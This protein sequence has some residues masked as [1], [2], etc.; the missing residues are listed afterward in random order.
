MS[1][2]AKVE[3]YVDEEGRTIN[4]FTPID[5]GKKKVI[6]GEV[7]LTINPPNSNEPPQTMPFEFDFPDDYNLSKAQKSFDDV[8]QEKIDEW[9]KEVRKKQQ[10]ENESVI[11]PKQGI[12]M[13][14]GRI[15]DNKQ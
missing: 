13:P 7:G 14:D 4:V 8:A 9:E 5:R 15:I 1:N 10:Q 11:T 3:K 12:M 6:R 2:W